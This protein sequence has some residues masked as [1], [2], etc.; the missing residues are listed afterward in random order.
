ML[1][2]KLI[3]YKQSCIIFGFMLHHVYFQKQTMPLKRST[4][5]CARPGLA[6]Q[7]FY[8]ACWPSGRNKNKNELIKIGYWSYQVV[9]GW[10]WGSQV[11]GKNTVIKILI[12]GD[13]LNIELCKSCQQQVI[14]AWFLKLIPYQDFLKT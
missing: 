4:T 8:E 9:S 14:H 5:L 11:T 1:I 6:T 10:P 3:S 7:H 2:M 13:C 12:H